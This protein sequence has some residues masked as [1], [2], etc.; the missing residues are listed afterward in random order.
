LR[1]LR[2]AVSVI[3]ASLLSSL[4]ASPPAQAAS[5]W[6]PPEALDVSGRGVDIAV[7][8]RGAAVA[9][10]HADGG[11][12]KASYRPAGATWGPPEVVS[13]EGYFGWVFI[14][15]SGAASA[16]GISQGRVRVSDRLPDGR[17]K[18]DAKAPTYQAVGECGDAYH[19]ADGDAAG[20]IVVTWTETQCEGS[21]SRSG[22]V[23]RFPDGS[24]RRVHEGEGRLPV[25]ALTVV[26]GEATL[27][28]SYG[29][30]GT[31]A[32]TSTRGSEPTEPQTLLDSGGVPD[33]ASN[34][35]GDLVVGI[36]NTARGPSSTTSRLV[37]RSKPAGQEWR[38]AQAS[39]W[40]AGAAGFVSVAIN[41]EGATAAV[42]PRVDSTRSQVL[43]SEGRVSSEERT[44]PTSVAGDLPHSA[45]LADVAVGAD[46]ALAAAWSTNRGGGSRTVSTQ[47]AFRAPGQSWEAP[48]ELAGESALGHGWRQVEVVALPSG[49]F[50]AVLVDGGP[51]VSDH[52]D[53]RVRPVARMVAPRHDFVRGTKLRVSWRAT[54][55]LAGVRNVDVRVRSA[56]RE[57]GF[58]AWSMWRR[59]TTDTAAALTGEPGRTYCFAARARDRV[60]N[61][62]NWSPERCTTTPIDDRA[63]EARG[64]WLR[65]RNPSAYGQTLASTGVTG[66]RLRLADV[67]ARSLRLVARTCP[68]C[69]KV[70]VTH[71]TRDLGV[72]DLSSA[73]VRNRRAIM[74]PG[75]DEVRGGA[76]VVRVVSQDKPVY[77]DGLIAS[78]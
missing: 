54:D 56:R 19:A 49:M 7:N 71:G 23:W 31:W 27:V 63:F 52:V 34:T 67:S 11:V 40:E 13:R 69:G 32:R 35:R 6:T 75:Y 41:D 70:R 2:A 33:I 57:G 47:A 16:V 25:E 61:L 26:N 15:G 45:A 29:G 42:F 48:V 65:L 4:L 22:M 5:Q 39:T 28:G 30:L 8:Q 43:V 53:D 55:D 59:R 9:V 44:E 3:A 20:N 10:W 76:V 73:R 66:A 14:D 58:S 24:W 17:W 1:A 60:G 62:G 12:V 74:L 77:V 51:M 37:T 50:T 18:V 64:A 36:T 38:A 68:R 72:V 78:R 21:F 46:G